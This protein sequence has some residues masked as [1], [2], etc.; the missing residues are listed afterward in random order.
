MKKTYIAPDMVPVEAEMENMIAQS[1]PISQ[2][3]KGFG[4]AD[5]RGN[6]GYFD[7]E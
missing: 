5:S 1:I 4:D 3:Q 7:E 6:S 2:S